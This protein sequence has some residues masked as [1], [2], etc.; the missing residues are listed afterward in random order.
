MWKIQRSPTLVVENGAVTGCICVDLLSGEIRYIPAKAVIL[1][2]GGSHGI[3]R[4][5]SGPS[6]CCGEG[7]AAA[8]RAGAELIDMEMISFCPAV[9]LY[10][11]MYKGN[12]LPYIM[13]T[14]GY[15]QFVNKYGKTFTQRYL[16][17]HVETLALD[18]EWNKMLLSYV[19][20]KE[21]NSR[22]CNRYGGVY[23]TLNLSPDELREELYHDLPSL[24][25]GMYA[26]IMEIFHSGR[27]VTCAPFAI[28][29]K[30]VSG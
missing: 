11:E 5:N 23:Y 3:F 19:M 10:P 6:D 21:I 16:S 18:T 4:N 2:T 28:T 8:L 27:C 7:P 12:I 20:Q 30:V 25:K 17:P 26:D 13:N 15:G 29:S 14:T 1:A 24:S 22:R 9:I